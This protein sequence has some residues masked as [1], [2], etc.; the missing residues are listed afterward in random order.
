MD[1]EEYKALE[2]TA[3]SIITELFNAKQ[4]GLIQLLL[5]QCALSQKQLDPDSFRKFI[6]SH[7]ASIN[8]EPT[9][10]TCGEEFTDYMDLIHHK[11]TNGH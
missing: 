10:K 3:S 8:G 6:K 5:M 4:T 9:C 1:S 2:H 11:L 7:F